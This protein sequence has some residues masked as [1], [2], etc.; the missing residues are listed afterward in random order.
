M[1]R[2][3]KASQE[4]GCRYCHGSEENPDAG[5]YREDFWYEHR[6]GDECQR[7]VFVDLAYGER[8]VGIFFCRV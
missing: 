7:T 3:T 8:G 4:N 1:R 5:S 2:G 6:D